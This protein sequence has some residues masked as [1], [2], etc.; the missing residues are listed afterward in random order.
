MYPGPAVPLGDEC[1]GTIVALGG[2]VDDLR[3]GD[4]VVA[5][6]V[7]ALG[8]FA[9]TDAR[10]VARKPAGLSFEQ[11]A[12]IPIAFLTATYALQGLAN[13]SA[14]ER[15]LIHAASGGVG[16]AAL[17]VARRSGAEIFATAGTPK[18]RE[19][20]RSLGVQHVMDSRS[21]DFAPEV[22][23]RTAGEGIDIVLNCLSGEATRRSVLLLRKGGRFLELGKNGILSPEQ[24]SQLRH[25]I[26]Y[27]VVALDRLCAE[28]PDDVAGLLGT[29]LSALK[30][31]SLRALPFERFTLS[32]AGSAFRHM[33]Q[34]RHIGKVVLTHG[35]PAAGSS[36]STIAGPLRDDA[37]YLITGG[38]GG[39]GLHVAQWMVKEGARH[40]VLLG[41]GGPSEAA[42]QTIAHLQAAGAQV[43]V[44]SAD[45]CRADHLGAALDD[46]RRS[47]PALRGV[48][49]AASILDDGVLM[50]QSWERFSRVMAPAVAGAWNLH[51]LTRNSPLD[52]FVLFSS[53]AS[54]L[55]SPGQGNYAAEIGR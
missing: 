50:Q 3:V 7:G 13:I 29:I 19:F 46:V 21:L 30:E 12:T 4:E 16:M 43:Q 15:V 22:M 14:G 2:G 27:F 5:V 41:R 40:L 53:A 36:S 47:M 45:V 20:L 25:D 52:S 51:T 38:L 33:A 42:R 18:K 1:A 31:G 32:D 24:L 26:A 49:H 48:L 10:L 6:A 35:S 17:Q 34:A 39:I 23:A 11:A 28:K 54:I 37:T 9:T 8:T 55:G 44:V